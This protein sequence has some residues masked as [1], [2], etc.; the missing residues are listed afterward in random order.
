[1][2]RRGF[3]FVLIIIISLIASLKTAAFA[4]AIYV[5]PS[6]LFESIS[7]QQLR[8]EGLSPRL[9]L[10]YGG[11]VYDERWYLAGEIFFTPKSIQIL[12]NSING[13][14][15]KV[16]YEWG[17]S[18]LPGLFL[19][20]ILMIY[21]RLGIIATHFKDLDI[22]RKGT[23]IGG[24]LEAWLNDTWSVRGEFDYTRYN[25]INS[26]GSPTSGTFMISAIYRFAFL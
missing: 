25:R 15:L 7:T 8:Y 23:Q 4:G 5:A 6:A 11:I 20:D 12:R 13:Q 3:I 26:I 1:M 22:T 9:D 2:F 16:Q 10:G 21:V 24:G 14:D 19:D 17:A 18:L